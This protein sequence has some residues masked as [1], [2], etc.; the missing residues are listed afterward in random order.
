MTLLMGDDEGPTD[1]LPDLPPAPEKSPAAA[2]VS[3]A[4]SRTRYQFTS[5]IPAGETAN[6]RGDDGAVVLS[7]RSFA[8]VLGVVAALMAA[9]VLIAGGAGVLFL[10]FEGR[11]MTAFIA[12]LLSLGFAG[13]I[14]ML[15][16]ATTVT[17]YENAAPVLTISQLSSVSFPVVSFVVAT[18]DGQ[19]I[20]RLRKNF[21]SRMGRNRWSILAAQ[22]GYAIEESL[23]R[24][25]LRKVAG[26]F[27]ARYQSN[28]LLVYA[29]REA[30]WIVRR[31]ESEEPADRLDLAPDSTLDRRLAVALATLVLGAEP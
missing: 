22:S 26:K 23:S 18:A 28:V 19:I 5:G 4:F 6:I 25:L 12:M 2:T 11:I 21:F 16:P 17:L 15:V 8:S 14:V 24:A 31:S 7:Y 27:N 30:G 3:S 1:R 13:V 9:I 29:D 20:G 10:V